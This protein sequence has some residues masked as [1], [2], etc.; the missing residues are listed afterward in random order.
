V[1]VDPQAHKCNV[2][3]RRWPFGEGFLPNRERATSKQT[4]ANLR[5]RVEALADGCYDLVEKW[6]M[7]TSVRKVVALQ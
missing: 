6:P 4:F 3:R 1:V 2:Q 5:C 7:I